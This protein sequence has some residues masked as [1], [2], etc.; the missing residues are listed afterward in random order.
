MKRILLIILILS[1]SKYTEA[2]TIRVGIINGEE[3]VSLEITG[4]V[5]IVDLV[6]DEVIL[7][8]Y[9][10]KNSSI[11]TTQ[12]GLKVEGIERVT[13]HLL[14]K[15]IVG[16][17]AVVNGNK[18]RGEIEIQKNGNKVTV[19]NLVELEE[20]LYGILKNEM[21]DKAPIEALK[22]QAIIARTYVL[23]NLKKHEKEGYNV[24]SK[25]HCQLYKGLN[26]ET[27]NIIKAVDTTKGQIL[28]Y[29][30]DIAET[31]Y[32]AWCGGITT[33]ANAVWGRDI[34]YLT[35]VYDPFCKKIYPN[36]EWKYTLSLNEIR[37]ILNRNGLNM[38]NISSIQVGSKDNSGRVKELIINGVTTI[39]ANKFRLLVGSDKIWST[40][41][42]IISNGDK[43]TFQG[44]GKGHGVGLCQRGAVA[45]GELGYNYKQILGFYYPGVYLRSII[46]EEE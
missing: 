37:N 42:T 44:R 12:D 43:V 8:T 34:S 24:C 39:S 3:S 36:D 13:S 4:Y 16:A 28:T 1:L 5:E 35:E 30:G 22:A 9:G 21:T 10:W 26:T 38:D 27:E 25:I 40:I 17:R 15:P 46:F 20:Y 41:F 45:M 6:T 33:N 18:Y 29:N 31:F 2:I 19:I 7:T 32:H 14:L 11:Q 23:A